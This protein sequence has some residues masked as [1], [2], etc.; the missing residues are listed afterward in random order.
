MIA[1]DSGRF[2]TTTA[3]PLLIECC[4]WAVV[5]VVA[6]AVSFQAVVVGCFVASLFIPFSVDLCRIVHN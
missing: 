4:V 6:V 5:L 2:Y 1:G 3:T